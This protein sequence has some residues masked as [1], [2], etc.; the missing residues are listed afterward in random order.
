MDYEYLVTDLRLSGVA[1]EERGDTQYPLFKY[2]EE[3]IFSVRGKSIKIRDGGLLLVL[4]YD[5]EASA[6]A[7]TRH[8]SHDGHDLGRPGS[9]L[10]THVDYVSPPHWFQRGRIIVL[11]NGPG[12]LTD[13]HEVV[14]LLRKLLGTEFAGQGAV[15]DTE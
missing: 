13:D 5:N 9:G 7:E 1:I 15:R 8:I 14:A 6:K 10:G 2:L 3:P 11:Y 4:E 12:G